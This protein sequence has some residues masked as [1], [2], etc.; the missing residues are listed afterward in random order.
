MVGLVIELQRV[1]LDESVPVSSVLRKALVV[2]RKLS[3]TDF[4]R[5]ARSELDGY[6][7]EEDIPDYR[8]LIVELMARRWP[9]G[10]IPVATTDEVLDSWTHRAFIEPLPELEEMLKRADSNSKVEIMLSPRSQQQLMRSAG[11]NFHFAL[12]LPSGSLAGILSGARH[13]VLNWA[14]ELEERGIVGDGMTFTQKEREAAVMS[15]SPIINNTNNFYGDRGQ[16]QFMNN[17]PGGHQSIKNCGVDHEA[18]RSLI[19]AI[20]LEQTSF[21]ISKAHEDE[22]AAE[23]AT[24]EAQ[25]TSPNPKPSIITESLGTIRGFLGGT[26]VGAAGNLLATEISKL[27]SS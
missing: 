9:H 7:R 1:A 15:G 4:E 17:S 25:L 20:K 11:Q 21:R 6:D 22:L 18:L 8:R 13:A 12:H 27:L 2:A 3:L 5:W 24:V 23:I 14:L 10:W 16:S 26:A 19:A